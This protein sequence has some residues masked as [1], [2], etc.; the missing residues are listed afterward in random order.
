MLFEFDSLKEQKA[1]IRVIGVGGAGS[2]AIDRMV[3]SE[4][5]GVEFIAVNTDAQALDISKADVKIQIGKTITKGLGAGAKL[6]VGEAAAEE[7]A[8]AIASALEGSDLVFVTAGMGGG[9]GTGAAPVVAR[10]SKE[11]GALT[12]GIVTTPFRCE[13]PQRSK[14]G[15]EGVENL[16]QFLDTLIVIPNQRLLSIVERT[17][18]MVDAFLEADSVLLQATRGISDLINVPGL[19]NLDYADVKTTMEG[20]G[21]AI[22]GTGIASGEERAVL[23]A[24]TAISSPLLDDTN[25]HGAQGLLI[26]ITG[27]PDMS[28]FEVDE[29]ANLIFEEVGEQANIIM[30][31]VIDET[32]GEELRVTVIATGFHHDSDLKFDRKETQPARA[33]RP[34]APVAAAKPVEEIVIEA[35]VQDFVEPKIAPRLETFEDREKLEVPTYERQQS[36]SEDVIMHFSDDLSVPTYIRRQEGMTL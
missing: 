35:P 29:A 33:Y 12:I 25:I 13:G 20:M 4:L 26:N 19:I 31:A 24:Q 17:T 8:Q 34:V 15:K 27:G 10:I 36:E 32:M 16:R 3:D 11:I 1:R 18:S 23:A 22:M 30:G 14:R 5:S 21:D 9:T 2:N 28:L 6:H 7:D